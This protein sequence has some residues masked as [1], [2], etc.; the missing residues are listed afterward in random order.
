[1]A[2]Q[3]VVDYDDDTD[4]ATLWA[5]SYDLDGKGLDG[6]SD[7]ELATAVLRSL[8]ISVTKLAED[9][10]DGLVDVRYRVRQV[11]EAQNPSKRAALINALLGDAVVGAPYLGEE[12][13][14]WSLRLVPQGHSPGAKIEAVCAVGL[15]EFVARY[16]PDRLG[17]C[18]VSPCVH[19]FADRS[20][21]ASRTACS[22]Q[23]AAIRNSR[24][25][26]Q[27]HRTLS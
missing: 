20:R 21:N 22:R 3:I 10:L 23:C 26:R 7:P 15:A 5:N 2:L 12:D 17:I 9:D 14:S 18:N 6:L 11:F 4:R 16:G 25:Y 1:M 24:S 13:G 27:R 8:G 19:V